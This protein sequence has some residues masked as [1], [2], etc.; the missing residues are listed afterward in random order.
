MSRAVTGDSYTDALVPLACQ[1]A[2]AV[3]DYD[4]AEIARLLD[5]VDLTGLV[6]VLAAMVPDD[7]APS[8]LLGW[9]GHPHEYTRLRAAGVSTLAANS[10]IA[11]NEERRDV[12]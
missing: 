4:R 9:L 5:C 1:L 10:V 2:A 6:V 11:G 8:E 7:L 3:H 12:A